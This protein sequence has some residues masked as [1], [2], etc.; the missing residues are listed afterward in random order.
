[1]LEKRERDRI[2][3]AAEHLLSGI[4]DEESATPS[5]HG[6]DSIDLAWDIFEELFATKLDVLRDFGGPLMQNEAGQWVPAIPLPLYEGWLKRP[7][8][9]HVSPSG[10]LCQKKFWQMEEYQAHFAL[11]HIVRG[12]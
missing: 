10:L 2:Q 8:C 5:G 6:G 12:R 3:Y 1:M 9:T 11:E 4:H 7:R